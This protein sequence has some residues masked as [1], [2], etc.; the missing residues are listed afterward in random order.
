MRFPWSKGEEKG[1]NVADERD[2]D[3]L[4][5]DDDEDGE[6]DGDLSLDEFEPEV[7]A[8]VERLQAKERAVSDQRLAALRE[9][10]KEQGLDINPEGQAQVADPSRFASWMG[11]QSAQPAAA[12]PSTADPEP[13]EMPDPYDDKPGF[14]AWM[15][16]QIDTAAEAKADAKIK[17]LLDAQQQQS[18]ITY[19]RETERALAQVE[20]AL[21]RHFPPALTAMEHPDF[22]PMLM[23]GLQG[24]PLSSWRE[25]AQLAQ[26]ASMIAAQL[27]W[28]KAKQ[29]AARNQRGQFAQNYAEV[30]PSRGSAGRETVEANDQT[31]GEFMR[32]YGGT[33][34]EYEALRRDDSIDGYLAAKNRAK[35]RG[36]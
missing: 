30:A 36:R 3:L 29:P 1:E 21:Q 6:D 9:V 4:E 10:W 2:D 23:Q 33:R 18:Q 20:S 32:R 28:S 14:Q 27:D 25:P 5:Y 16:K 31:A 8:K 24:L 35:A 7:R 26:I 11:S 34:E 12:A 13:E 15:K 17:P 22:T 19:A